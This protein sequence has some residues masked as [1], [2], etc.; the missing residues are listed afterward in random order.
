VRFAD[1]REL[2]SFH[3]LGNERLPEELRGG[4][5]LFSPKLL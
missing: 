1:V 2:W 5:R 4:Q 3:V